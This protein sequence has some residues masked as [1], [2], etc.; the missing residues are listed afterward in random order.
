[1]SVNELN[2]FDY[3]VGAAKQCQRKGEAKR[4]GGLEIND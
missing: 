4:L 1:V 2:A 3:L